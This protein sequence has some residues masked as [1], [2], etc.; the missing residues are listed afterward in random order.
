MGNTPSKYSKVGRDVI[1]RMYAEGKIRGDISGID[2]LD[3]DFDSLEFKSGDKWYN[4]SEADMS[5]KHGKEA[6]TW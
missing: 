6:V 3:F 1:K 4:I 2:N 5:H